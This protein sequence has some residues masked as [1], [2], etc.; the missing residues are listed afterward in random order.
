MTLKVTGEQKFQVLAHSMTIGYSESGYT[1]C[2]GAGDGNF[3][4]W[5]E[6]TSANEV[7]MVVNFAKGTYFYLKNNVGEVTINY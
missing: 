1:L 6:A 2:Y 5:D 7:C 4:E 3:T